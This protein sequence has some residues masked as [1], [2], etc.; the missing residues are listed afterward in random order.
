MQSQHP[1]KVKS[2]GEEFKY[3]T[4]PVCVTFVEQHCLSSVI[5]S[6][7]TREIFYSFRSQTTSALH[8]S[9]DVKHIWFT[10]YFTTGNV[11]QLA[12]WSKLQIQNTK[13]QPVSC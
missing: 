2:L 6:V 7:I 10:L 5:P 1:R 13:L 8:L 9:V 4:P 3:H 11:D 12:L